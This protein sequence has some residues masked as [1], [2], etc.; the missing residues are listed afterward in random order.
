M[1]A[2]ERDLRRYGSQG[3]QRL[4]LLALL[5]AERDVLRDAR[6]TSPV[7]LLDDVLS[8]LDPSRRAN[9]LDTLSDRGQALLSTADERTVPVDAAY[10]RLGVRAPAGDGED[11]RDEAGEVA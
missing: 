1:R 10:T 8:E 7:M 3:Q 11:S 2:A 6:D 5:L 4:A 9:L